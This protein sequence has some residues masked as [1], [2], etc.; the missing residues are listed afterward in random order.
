MPV[1][2][3][4]ALSWGKNGRTHVGPSDSFE[5]QVKLH[6][7]PPPPPPDLRIQCEHDLVSGPVL[8]AE[9]LRDLGKVPTAAGSVVQESCRV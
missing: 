8:G 5:F 4:G 1:P 3:Q 6:A 9:I 2:G 7:P